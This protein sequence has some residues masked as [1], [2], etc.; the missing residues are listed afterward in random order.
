MIQTSVSTMADY[1]E[2]NQSSINDIADSIKIYGNN[3]EQ[4][5]SDTE[6]IRQLVLTMEAEISK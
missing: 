3:V 1:S 4:M 6:N 5:E 2:K